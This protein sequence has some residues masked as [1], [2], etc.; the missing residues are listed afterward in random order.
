[1]VLHFPF[2]L[3]DIKYKMNNRLKASD[4]VC[5]QFSSCISLIKAF[6]FLPD[7]VS[8]SIV[9]HSKAEKC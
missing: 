7:Q 5:N 2:Y 6:D 8:H 4:Y 9:G 1:M 3:I